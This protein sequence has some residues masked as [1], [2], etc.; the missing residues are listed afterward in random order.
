MALSTKT[1]KRRIKS[2]SNTKKITKAME[3][4]SAVK[5]RRAVAQNAA[6]RNYEHEASEMLDRIIL[7]MPEFIHPLFE[8]REIKKICIIL[9]TSNRGLA[10]GFTSKLLQETHVF[11]TNQ[12]KQNPNLEVEIFLMGKKGQKIFHQF[13]HSISAEFP[14]IDLTTK[15]SEVL[16]LARLATKEFLEKKYDQ[17]FIAYTHFYSALVQTPTI[18]QILPISNA[19]RKTPLV[20][21]TEN[22]EDEFESDEENEGLA[23]PDVLFEPTPEEVLKTLLPEF[24]ELKIYQSILESD[25]SEHSA[26]MM[27]MQKASDSAKEMINELQT[28]YNKAR[29]AAITQEIMEVIGGAAALE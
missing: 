15:N 11:I 6:S 25:A 26:R 8:T 12:K 19:I 10:G 28:S 4:I 18:K 7:K 16:P 21:K 14:K 1:I 2:I 22:D 20:I 9:V 29:Q 3:M 13:K 23:E 17:I 5:M 24:T 27:A